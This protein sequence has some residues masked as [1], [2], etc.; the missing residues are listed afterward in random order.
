MYASHPHDDRRNS[1]PLPMTK[2]ALR[3]LERSWAALEA[4]SVTDDDVDPIVSIAAALDGRRR[5]VL[6]DA[7]DSAVV[8]APDGRV[9]VGLD[10]V[11][12]DEGRL[13]RYSIVPPGD[14]ISISSELAADS[15]LGMALIGHRPGDRVHVDAPAGTRVVEIVD[16][17]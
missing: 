14:G 2:A 13:V 5:Q 10:V 16:V 8:M 9:I 6:R 15:P 4:R 12:R 11:I 1:R 7:M 17:R 3:R